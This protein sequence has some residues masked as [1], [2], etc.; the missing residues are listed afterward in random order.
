METTKP[1][2]TNSQRSG[3][4]AP[5]RW[6]ATEYAPRK[7]WW[8][9]VLTGL[10][11]LWLTV[12]LF[13][14]AD[15]SL[16][17]VALVTTIAIF[18]WYVPRPRTFEFELTERA[19]RIDGGRIQRRLE[20]YRAIAFERIPQRKHRPPFELIVLLPRARFS[21]ALDVYLPD[22]DA[23]AHRIAEKLAETLPLDGERTNKPTALDKMASWLRLR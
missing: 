16:A 11:G 10:L 1:A 19:L 12:F 5:L 8:W 15:W 6:R 14:I 22:D 17:C 18:R 13:A 7:S 23:Q 3:G 21:A 2:K 9:F 20:G 4:I